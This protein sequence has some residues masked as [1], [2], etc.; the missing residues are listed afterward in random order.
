MDMEYDRTLLFVMDTG[1]IPLLLIS[2]VILSSFFCLLFFVFSLS[3]ISVFLT[4]FSFVNNDN[5]RFSHSCAPNL[6]A[7]Q[8]GPWMDFY[9]LVDIPQGTEVTISYIPLASSTL[10][11]REYLAQEYFFYCTCA[12]CMAD[13]KPTTQEVAIRNKFG[14]K[15]RF[16]LDT[17]NLT[18]HSPTTTTTTTAEFHKETQSD[19]KS[20]KNSMNVITTRSSEST[21]SLA[22]TSTSTISTSTATILSSNDKRDAFWKKFICPNLACQGKG[23]YFPTA[24]GLICSLCRQPPPGPGTNQPIQN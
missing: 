4:L 15:L 12:R 21:S 2:S 14:K 11:R 13:S 23:L 18:S 3:I 6:V 19:Q 16:P 8:E 7:V 10:E 24:H 5:E 17:E 1:S 20:E 9:A 22:P